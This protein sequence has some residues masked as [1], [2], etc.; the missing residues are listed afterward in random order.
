MNPKIW[1]SAG[2]KFLHSITLH[3]PDNPSQQDKKNYKNFF[4]SLQF[5]I[6]CEKCQ[7]HYQEN[8]QK[9]SLDNALDN[10]E[11]FFDWLVDIHNG[12][13]I[14][15]NKKVL[16]YD[17]VKRIYEDLYSNKKNKNIFLLIIIVLIIIIFYLINNK[18]QE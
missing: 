7:K 1:G 12:V 14:K 18:C 3:Y 8:L 9:Y 6:P 10:K 2:W 5:T 16:S 4:E 15:N 13:N 11:S 17:K